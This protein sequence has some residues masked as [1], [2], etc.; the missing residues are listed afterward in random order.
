MLR[1]RS[2]SNGIVAIAIA[3]A[4]AASNLAFA[5]QPAH[6]QPEANEV[7][8]VQNMTPIGSAEEYDALFPSGYPSADKPLSAGNEGESTDEGATGETPL[9]ALF[10]AK[11]CRDDV[12]AEAADRR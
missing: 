1:T 2:R 8:I 3:F 11:R 6:A 9:C 5:P 12:L 7:V 10:C 4:L